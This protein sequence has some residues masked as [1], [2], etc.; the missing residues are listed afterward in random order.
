MTLIRLSHKDEQAVFQF[1]WQAGI[2]IML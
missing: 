1:I 2:K